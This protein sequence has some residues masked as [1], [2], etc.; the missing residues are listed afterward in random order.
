MSK[1][2]EFF[3]SHPFSK[4]L[5]SSSWQG[6]NTA[7]S[8]NARQSLFYVYNMINTLIIKTSGLVNMKKQAEPA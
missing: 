8:K 2:A 3:Y 7:E 1:E 6:L 4:A 5:F